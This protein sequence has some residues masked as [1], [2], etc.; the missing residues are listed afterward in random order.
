MDKFND[1]RDDLP[2][3]RAPRKAKTI[4]VP[5]ETS[6]RYIQAHEDNFKKYH[7]QAYA[8]GG[9]FK[10]VM[11]DCRKANGL[12][13]AIIKF[14]LWE[15]HRATG[16]DSGGRMRKINGEHKFIPGR[17]RKGAA[18]VSSTIN[19]RSCM[20]EVKVGKDKP[21]PEQIREQELERKAGGSYEFVH[22]FK[23]FLK[24]YDEL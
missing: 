12:T 20:W 23:E 18:D 17:T 1:F 10:P 14:L 19:G 13:Q 6:D 22:S 15:G 2:P 3:L 5:R 16:I 24:Y 11:P 8:T 7:P 9:Y 4:H 21:S